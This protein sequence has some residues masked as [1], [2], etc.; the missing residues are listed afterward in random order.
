[1][2]KIWY[3]ILI[4]PL[5]PAGV[6]MVKRRWCAWKSQ[7]APLITKSMIP[8]G[9]DVALH[10]ACIWQ[11]GMAHKEASLPVQ[12]VGGGGAEAIGHAD[13]NCSNRGVVQWDRS[14]PENLSNKMSDRSY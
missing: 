10:T 14:K 11:A 3:P 7:P 1:M 4:D 8:S 6:Q 12:R 9:G 2:R 5:M 13:L